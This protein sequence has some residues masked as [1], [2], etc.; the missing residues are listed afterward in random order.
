MSPGARAR[1]GGRWVMPSAQLGYPGEQ[2][3]RLCPHSRGGTCVT[4]NLRAHSQ[5]SCLGCH[6][7]NA[8]TTFGF[9]S[10]KET[11]AAS[12]MPLVIAGVRIEELQAP[13]PPSTPR[14]K[15]SREH[16]SC[17]FDPNFSRPTASPNASFLAENFYNENYI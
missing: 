8:H 4:S 16:A 7:L 15:F 9:F 3:L 10:R 12:T 11:V 13:L 1:A 6:S 5:P 14:F 2:P 17:V